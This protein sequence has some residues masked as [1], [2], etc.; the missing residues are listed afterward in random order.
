MLYNKKNIALLALLSV[1]VAASF[2]ARAEGLISLSEDAMFDDE[3]ESNSDALKP[4]DTSDEVPEVKANAPEEPAEVEINKEEALAPLPFATPEEKILPTSSAAKKNNES[5][6]EF[7]NNLFSQMSELEK[8]TTLMNLELR[9]EKLQNEIEA[10]K[11]QRKQAIIQ[12]QEKAEA[13]RLKNIEK[14]KELERKLLVEQEK[15]RELDLKFEKLRQEKL[16]GSYKNKML[17][18]NQKWI[19]HDASFYKQISDLR[20]QKRDMAEATKAKFKEVRS[21]AESAKASVTAQIA[22]YKKTNADLQS[23]VNILKNRVSSLERERDEARRNPFAEGDGALSAA[24]KDG[25]L[26]EISNLEPNRIGLPQLYAI[27]EIRGQGGE[28][29]AKLVNKSGTSFYVKKG[30]T[31]QSGHVITEITST[32]VLAEKNGEKGYIYF[33]A[34]GILPQETEKFSIQKDDIEE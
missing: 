18:E 23:Q 12:E 10:V 26:P 21:A 20:Q 17:E 30:T 24:G 25:F 33:A 32:Y 11:N 16:L 8:R 7:S 6:A 28:L 14:E 15:L 34:G 19:E 3:L 2:K 29:I 22:G 1:L 27:T 4:S 13:V 5:E 9:R 31:L